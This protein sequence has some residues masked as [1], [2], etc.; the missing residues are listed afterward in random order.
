MENRRDVAQPLYVL[1]HSLV[2]FMVESIGLEKV[3]SLVQSSNI[4]ASAESLTGRTVEAWKASW[5]TM[6]NSARPPVTTSL[7]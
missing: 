7:R 3:K 4:T 6:L 5:L 2:K 1:A